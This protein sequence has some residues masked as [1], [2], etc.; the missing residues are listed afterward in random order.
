MFILA[1]IMLI[2][3]LVHCAVALAEFTRS[4]RKPGLSG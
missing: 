3:V 2:S 4:E 1:A